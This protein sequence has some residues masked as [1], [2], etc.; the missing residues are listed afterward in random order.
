M[1]KVLALIICLALMFSLAACSHVGEITDILL[2]LFFP[3]LIPSEPD[4]SIT[5]VIPG[6]DDTPDTPDTPDEPVVPNEPDKPEVP[7]TPDEPD[8]PEAPDTPDEPE[9]PDT[10]EEPAE[11]ASSYEIR[12]END[13]I[14]DEDPA[15]PSEIG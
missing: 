11:V 4:D 3:E 6:K 1:K 14:R 8:E 5:V 10:P 7:D 13:K 2:E 9:V 12:L 15:S